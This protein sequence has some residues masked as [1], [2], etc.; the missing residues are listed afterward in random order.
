MNQL[1][2]EHSKLLKEQQALI[3]GAREEN[4]D[5]INP[6]SVP[7]TEK[8]HKKISRNEK[9]FSLEFFPPKTF[10]GATNLMAIAG[11]IGEQGKPL[12]CDISWKSSPLTAVNSECQEPSTLIVAAALSDFHNLDVMMHI[13]SVHVTKSQVMRELQKA[14]D[15]GIRNIL[16]L[17]GVY[18]QESS[19][20]TD[21]DTDESDG[22]FEYTVDLVKFIRKEFDDY[23]TIAVA[24]KTS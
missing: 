19:V 5:N 7:L 9:F 12:F 13:P 2:P 15:V 17:R 21:E 11:R 18:D 8:L 3:P 22:G 6:H 4:M 23:F 16:A 1:D 10:N 20:I 14:K 24:G